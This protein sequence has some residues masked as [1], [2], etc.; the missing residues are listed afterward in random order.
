M[1][2]WTWFVSQGIYKSSGFAGVGS[3][4]GVGFV[5]IWARLVL[6]GLLKVLN[7]RVLAPPSY[8]ALI[9]QA[10]IMGLWLVSQGISKSSEFPGVGSAVVIGFAYP[11][12]A[13]IL[14]ISKAFWLR[15]R[16]W[17]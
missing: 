10:L 8:F 17:L 12:L 15:R 16:G 13:Y 1:I 7:L 2:I 3:A 14:R 6:Q 4:I 11:G 9:I 5:I